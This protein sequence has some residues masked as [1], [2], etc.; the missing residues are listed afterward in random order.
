MQMYD[1]VIAVQLSN[2]VLI[3][4]DSTTYQFFVGALSKIFGERS[5]QTK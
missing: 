2:I 5:T 4:Y 3:F 1:T